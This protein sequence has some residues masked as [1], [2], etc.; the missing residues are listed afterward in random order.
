MDEIKTGLKGSASWEV[1]E[2]MTARG[3]RSGSLPVLATPMLVALMEC[4]AC[5]AVKDAL[6]EGATSVGTEIDVKHV[7]ASGVGAAVRAE[8][9]LTA[10]EGRKL[11]FEISAFE[12]DKLIGTASHT[13]F[14]VDAQ[15]FMSK[16]A[17]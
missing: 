5:N 6:Q 11:S 9:A 17:K 16:L 15:R 13:R 1:T 8:A 2:D 14:I 7:A 10:A 4:A 12:G 3:C